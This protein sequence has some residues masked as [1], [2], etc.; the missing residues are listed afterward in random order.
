LVL[1][2]G[3]S[4]KHGRLVATHCKRQLFAANKI[5]S[6]LACLLGGQLSVQ[7]WLAIVVIE[8][9]ILELVVVLRIEAVLMS[10]IL[11]W[12][13]THGGMSGQASEL[14]DHCTFLDKDSLRLQIELVQTT[15]YILRRYCLQYF[16]QILFCPGWTSRYYSAHTSRGTDTHGMRFYGKLRRHINEFYGC[17]ECKQLLIRLQYRTEFHYKLFNTLL[18]PSLRPQPKQH[19]PPTHLRRPLPLRSHLLH[20]QHYIYQYLNLAPPTSNPHGVRFT[21]PIDATILEITPQNDTLTLLTGTFSIE[22]HSAHY[23]SLL[24]ASTKLCL[25]YASWAVNNTLAPTSILQDPN[26]VVCIDERFNLTSWM[27][28][29]SSQF[30]LRVLGGL[31]WKEIPGL[32]GER[33][34]VRWGRRHV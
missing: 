22:A 31:G 6:Q 15:F 17:P 27:R 9:L 28:E 23:T 1:G 25:G 5:V 16:V 21:N 18:P 4:S 10:K 32:S 30:P 20:P 7:A 33:G 14:S 19:R 29:S 12:R 2:R 34:R 24:V 13:L 26:D 11:T 3:L 8:F